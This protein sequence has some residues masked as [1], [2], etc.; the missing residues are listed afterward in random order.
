MK[1]ARALVLVVLAIS[2][3]IGALGG[4]AT[5]DSDRNDGGP[6]QSDECTMRVQSC[7]NNCA[8]AD[9][10]LG[11]KMCCDRNGIACDVGGDYSFHSCMDTE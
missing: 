4:C 7:K 1:T 11:C 8:R 6:Q 9:L 2:G 10:G 3:T 5:T